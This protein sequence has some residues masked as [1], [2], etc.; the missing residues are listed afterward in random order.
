MCPGMESPT[1]S[2]LPQSERHGIL[3]QSVLG[4]VGASK[5]RH[6]RG[7]KT[8]TNTPQKSVLKPLAVN[9]AE[10]ERMIGRRR[11]HFVL[12]TCM[13]SIPGVDRSAAKG[14][15]GQAAV[16]RRS[17]SSRRRRQQQQQR[18]DAMMHPHTHLQAK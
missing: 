4:A 14:T 10:V 11:N 8:S 7:S 1:C 5:A 17:S 3:E 6:F 18:Q 2:D 9:A 15:M 13:G 12:V 16:R